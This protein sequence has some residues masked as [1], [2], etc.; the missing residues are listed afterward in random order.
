MENQLRFSFFHEY[1]NIRM[2]S[3]RAQRVLM[4]Y[5]GEPTS[6]HA[7]M[8][9]TVLKFLMGIFLKCQINLATLMQNVNKPI[10]EQRK[11]R[12]YKK[13]DKKLFGLRPKRPRPS[14]NLISYS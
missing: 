4:D 3:C 12:P 10:Y 11:T 13:E 8:H 1:P 14:A 5:L 6:E 7:C 2:G 9:C